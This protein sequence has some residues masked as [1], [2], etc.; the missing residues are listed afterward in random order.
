MTE[1]MSDHTT[2]DDEAAAFGN[3]CGM[4]ADE[5]FN[6]GEY[7]VANYRNPRGNVSSMDEAF[8]MAG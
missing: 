2:M 3:F 8:G 6:W 1:E 5:R 4:D 7:V